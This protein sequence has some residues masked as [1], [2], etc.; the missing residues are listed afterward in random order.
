MG[1]LVVRARGGEYAVEEVDF[2]WEVWQASRESIEE[3]L[4]QKCLCGDDTC[5]SDDQQELWP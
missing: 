4:P 5:K 1:I 3:E 2:A